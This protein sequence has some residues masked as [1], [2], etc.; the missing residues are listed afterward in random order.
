MHYLGETSVI[1]RILRSEFSPLELRDVTMEAGLDAI[2]YEIAGFEDG[3]RGSQAQEFWETLGAGKGKKRIFSIASR[4]ECSLADTLVKV[5][6]Y[7][8]VKC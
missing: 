3:G 2:N 6:T 5:L 8:A 1:T 4:K 7:R